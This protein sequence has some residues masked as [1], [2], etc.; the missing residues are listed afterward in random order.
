MNQIIEIHGI[1]ELHAKVEEL[2]EKLDALAARLSPPEDMLDVREAA[3]LMHVNEDTMRR[4][5]REGRVPVV[6]KG[7]K[8]LFRRGDLVEAGG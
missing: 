3:K 1:A 6:R 7:Q 2:A 5:A 8:M 4:Y